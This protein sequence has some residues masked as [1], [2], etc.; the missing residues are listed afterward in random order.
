MQ[1]TPYSYYTIWHLV[2]QL[3][4]FCPS[5]KFTKKILI[6]DGNHDT[7]VFF[8]TTLEK[9][10]FDVDAYTDPIAALLKFK[11]YSYD[12]C[13]IGIRSPRIS[14]FE[15]FRRIRKI[16]HRIKVCFI[17]T[18]SVYHQAIREEHPTLDANCF[19]KKKISSSVLVNRIRL[20]L[21]MCTPQNSA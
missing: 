16:D 8:K 17:T 21:N 18:F 15:F 1:K 4:E 9:S 10:G 20:E 2:Y 5:N 19:I 3:K 7:I 13:V 11:P 12:L 14:G 6:V